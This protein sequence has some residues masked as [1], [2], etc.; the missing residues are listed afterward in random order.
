M[1]CFL[2][3]A[4]SGSPE[5]G[6]KVPKPSKAEVKNLGLVAWKNK[7]THTPTYRKLVEQR[8]NKCWLTIVFLK[9]KKLSPDYQRGFCL[10]AMPAGIS[11]AVFFC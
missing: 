6:L 10:K 1:N 8:N 2:G 7:H 4:G 5:K 11:I 9:A 3:L